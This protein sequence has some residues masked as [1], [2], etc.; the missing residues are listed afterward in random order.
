[1]T[2][3]NEN[4]IL[5]RYTI[6]QYH[7]KGRNK[8]PIGVVIATRI[9]DEV[10]FGYSLCMKEDRKDFSKQEALERTVEKAQEGNTQVPPS[11][12]HTYMTVYERAIKYFPEELT[13]EL[14]G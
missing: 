10:R 12:N 9:G 14:R 1:M 3:I 8:R 13:V 5:P 2:D 7:R 11:M 6:V 4:K